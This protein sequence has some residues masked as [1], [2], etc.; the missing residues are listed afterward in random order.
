MLVARRR[1]RLCVP[2]MP[3]TARQILT[4]DTVSHGDLGL[5]PCHT[6][7]GSGRMDTVKI[8][9]QPGSSRMSWPRN[10]PELV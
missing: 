8:P 10:G 6:E 5:T 4:F 3:L 2:G 9:A 7:E 1:E